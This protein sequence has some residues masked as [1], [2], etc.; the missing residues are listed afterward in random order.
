MLCLACVNKIIE[1]YAF[2]RMCLNSDR[3]QRQL[4]K[5]DGEMTADLEQRGGPPL[6]S[7][8][9]VRLGLIDN[10]PSS[11]ENKDI[12]AG[13]LSCNGDSG[14]PSTVDISKSNTRIEANS[15]EETKFELSES[16]ETEA[17]LIQYS[18][19]YYEAFRSARIR[20]EHKAVD[21]QLDEKLQME[22]FHT[23]RRWICRKCEL[24]FSSRELLR[25]HRYIHRNLNKANKHNSNAEEKIGE[26]ICD[27]CDKIFDTKH[28]IRIHLRRHSQSKA[29]CN[30]CGKWLSRNNLNKHYRAI[31]L[32]EKKHECPICHHRFT[33]SF[34]LKDHVN[35]HKGIRAYACEICPNQFFTSS[36]AKRHMA[37]VHTNEK[38][39]A[40]SI[41][42][43]AFNRKT[44][45]KAHMFAHT[46]KYE[47]TCPIC[48]L[49]FR[50]RKKLLHHLDLC[51]GINV[52]LDLRPNPGN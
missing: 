27:I 24:S 40:C 19:N 21:I 50:R 4:L 39:F 37:T 33:S 28:R 47:H 26:F 10:K 44:N 52:Q 11:Q 34:R 7:N 5:G 20:S 2:Y 8:Y 1:F 30:A 32:N 15:N 46:G 42:D 51:K 13:S 43:K 18:I 17:H 25:D 16:G 12:S 38:R 22:N 6:K 35:S 23:N 3:A 41:C 45:L 36:A 14:S 48:C 49:G 31:H 9:T 29:L